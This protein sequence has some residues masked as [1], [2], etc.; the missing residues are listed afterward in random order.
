MIIAKLFSQFYFS[1]VIIAVCPF[2]TE[3]AVVQMQRGALDIPLIISC[4]GIF[5]NIFFFFCLYLRNYCFF[6]IGNWKDE[7]LEHCK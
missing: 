7:V 2:S 5:V 3:T 4:I 1:E 6:C